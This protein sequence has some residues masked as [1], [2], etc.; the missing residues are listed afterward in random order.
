MYTRSFVK[1][2]ISYITKQSN[3]AQFVRSLLVRR[4]G[5]KVNVCQKCEVE[6]NF[7]RNSDYSC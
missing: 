2:R 6:N 5:K 3:C 7:A 4:P 1:I